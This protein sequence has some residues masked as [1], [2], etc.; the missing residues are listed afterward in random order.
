MSALVPLA[1]TPQKPDRKLITGTSS[2]NDVHTVPSTQ[3]SFS[4]IT[5][6]A[7]ASAHGSGVLVRLFVYDGAT[8]FLFWSGTIAAN[9]A[10]SAELPG[11]PLFLFQGEKLKADAATADVITVHT[12]GLM[13]AS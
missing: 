4:A 7:I 8:D 11:L 3:N 5:S 6:I 13:F 9:G 10:L 12:S 2:K 1:G